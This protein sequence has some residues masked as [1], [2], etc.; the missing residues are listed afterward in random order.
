MNEQMIGQPVY[1]ADG[2]EL[3]TVKEVR[4]E[5]F[6]VDA[7][8]QPDYWLRADS[9]QTTG[10]RLVV[11]DN[12]EHFDNPDDL[13][14]G[15]YTR[16]DRVTTEH[17]HHT[18]TGREQM[19]GEDAETMRLR[20]ERLRVGTER[21]Q[22]GEVQLGKRVT[23]R[24]ETVEVPVREERVVVERRPVNERAT[25]GEI[26]E[27]DRTIEVPVERERVRAE[28]EAV[29]TEEVGVRKEVTERSQPVQANLRKEEL[30]VEGEGD[31]IE[32]G[33]NLNARDETYQRERTQR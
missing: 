5:Y 18:G 21:E 24:T 26:T 15:T 7:P 9:C 31:V 2:G 10:G 12:A 1:G 8:M 29:V 19:T 17:A 20:E 22:A 11:M 28:K 16:G 14:T 27:T 32:G 25:S 13:G 23:E 30:V 33:R 6:K 4:G 3:G